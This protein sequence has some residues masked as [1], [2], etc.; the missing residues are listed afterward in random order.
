M[1]YNNRMLTPSQN[2][3]QMGKNVAMQQKQLNDFNRQFIQ[4]QLDVNPYGI[5]QQQLTEM[6]M[7]P[8]A[9][10]GG[11]NNQS[12]YSYSGLDQNFRKA[13]R[14]YRNKSR[15]DRNTMTSGGFFDMPNT[16]SQTN[17]LNTPFAADPR[18]SLF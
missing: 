15:E 1:P 12:G 4:A 10:F 5:T 17:F 8:G 6:Q 14:M 18:T 16:T 13:K 2:P 11:G 9:N 3:Y 7:M